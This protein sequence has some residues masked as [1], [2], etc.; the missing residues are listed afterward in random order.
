MTLTK[1]QI[2]KLLKGAG[3]AAIAAGLTYALAFFDAIDVDVTSPLV[4]ALLG[5]LVNAVKVLAT[6]QEK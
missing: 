1:E 3:I 5:M 4:Y 2:G 6:K